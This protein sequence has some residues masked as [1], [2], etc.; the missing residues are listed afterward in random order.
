MEASK[1]QPLERLITAL[2]IRGIGEIAAEDLSKHFD[3]LDALAQASA[4]ELEKIEGFGP[5]MAEAIVDWFDNPRNQEIIQKLKNAGVWA[6]KA[7][8]HC[9]KTT[10]ADGQEICGDRQLYRNF[11]REG[12][13]DY[14]SA[15]GGKVSD[16]VSAKTD[17]LVVGENPGSKTG[18]SQRAGRG[19]PERSPVERVSRARTIV[20]KLILKSSREKSLL[21]RHPWV[22]FGRYTKSR[23]AAR[24]RRQRRDHIFER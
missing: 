13:K 6:G 11:T 3:D 24:L 18:K 5:N 10:D 17:Y 22:F 7:D 23:R 20:D 9:F 16:S 14:I 4:E 2:G 15:Y 12:I 21:R 8:K 1:S 19:D